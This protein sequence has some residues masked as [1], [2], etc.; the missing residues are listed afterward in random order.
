MQGWGLWV[1]TIR[2]KDFW[3]EARRDAAVSGDARAEAGLFISRRGGAHVAPLLL[4]DPA[5]SPET[6]GFAAGASRPKA[7]SDLPQDN[8]SERADWI[9]RQLAADCF[10]FAR[11]ETGRR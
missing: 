11:P 3:T 7:L 5:G 6:A 9:A 1:G 8:P 2:M 4:R 10:H